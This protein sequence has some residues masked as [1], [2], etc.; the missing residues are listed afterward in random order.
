MKTR[1]GAGIPYYHDGL[2]NGY[3][4]RRDF[5]MPSV[6][7]IFEE[8]PDLAERISQMAQLVVDRYSDKRRNLGK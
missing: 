5:L 2:T 6:K 3:R 1:H 4:I 7:R 8:S